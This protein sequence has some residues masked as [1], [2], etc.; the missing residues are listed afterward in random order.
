[1]AIEIPKEKEL[2]VIRKYF[3]E[4]IVMVLLIAVVKMYVIQNDFEKEVRTQILIKLENST[5]A[6]NS[7]NL[8]LHSQS[9]NKFK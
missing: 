1:M 7:I 5:Q 9:Q 2:S 6:T 8:F 4:F 3:T